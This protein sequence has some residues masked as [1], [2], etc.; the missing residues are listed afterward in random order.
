M[1]S[2]KRNERGEKVNKDSKSAKLQSLHLM[3]QLKNCL[4]KK[5]KN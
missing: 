4:C 5:G 1:A 3:R 2:Q